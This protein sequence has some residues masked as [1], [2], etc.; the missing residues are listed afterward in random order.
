MRFKNYDS[1]WVIGAIL[2]EKTL[3]CLMNIQKNQ[4][5]RNIIIMMF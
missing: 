4:D 3:I 2:K 5:I 1:W